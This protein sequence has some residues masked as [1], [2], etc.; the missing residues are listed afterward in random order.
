[1]N[2]EKAKTRCGI[3]VFRIVDAKKTVDEVSESISLISKIKS[4]MPGIVECFPHIPNEGKRSESSAGILKRMNLLA[5]VSD[6]VL[7]KPS[8]NYNFLCIEL[9]VKKGS[10]ANANQRKFLHMVNKNGGYGCIA[11]GHEAALYVLE[12]Y[13][14][15]EKL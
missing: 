2:I 12:K 13:M 11:N 8:K 5:G 10:Y 6:Y 3:D 4:Q 7:F 9:K 1:M 15:N 14:N